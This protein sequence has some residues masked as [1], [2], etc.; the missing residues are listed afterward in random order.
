MAYDAADV[1]VSDNLATALSVYIQFN[2]AVIGMVRK[3]SKELIVL[4]KRW[5]NI[6]EKAM[7]TIQATT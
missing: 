3:P 7:K 6:S 5:A 2:I 4:A 1:M